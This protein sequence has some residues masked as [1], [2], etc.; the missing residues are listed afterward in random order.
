MDNQTSFFK[1]SPIAN[2]L[3]TQEIMKETPLIK[4]ASYKIYSKSFSGVVA[5]S[6][7]MFRI[8]LN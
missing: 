4:N 3:H 2:S 5:E 7:R 6:P 8:N 1:S